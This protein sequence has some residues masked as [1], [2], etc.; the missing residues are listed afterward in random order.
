MVP[1]ILWLASSL[2]DGITGVR[3]VGRLWDERLAPNEAAA[4]AREAPVLLPVSD[5]R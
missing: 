4:K 5:P 2:S 1:P 3:F